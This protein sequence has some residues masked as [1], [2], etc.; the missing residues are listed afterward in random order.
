MGS[1]WWGTW[2]WL[3]EV[4]IH[5]CGVLYFAAWSLSFYPQVILNHRRRSSRGLSHDF[6][7]LNVTGFFA[8]SLYTCIFRF[9]APTRLQFSQ[10][11][12]AQPPPVETSDVCFALHGLILTLITA[13]QTV[14]FHDSNNSN[15]NI[16]PQQHQLQWSNDDGEHRPLQSPSAVA[17]SPPSSSSSL[18]PSSADIRKGAVAQ[19]E[20][21]VQVEYNG[22]DE[23]EQE[24]EEE[25]SDGLRVGVV[26]MV[27]LMWAVIGVVSVCG[28]A[29]VVSGVDAVMTMGLIKA[30]CSLFKYM[31]QVWNN[32]KRRSTHGFSIHVV[33]LDVTGGVLSMLQQ[34]LRVI[35]AHGDLT[36]FTGNVAKTALALVSLVLDAIMLTQHYVLY[37]R[38]STPTSAIV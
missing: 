9:H 30:L 13:A 1:E 22:T 33:L 8:Y 10:S 2:S 7:A 12:N 16:N 27:V 5:T 28:W 21:G 20:D 11:H 34:T 26:V 37:P 29:G 4:G 31:P 38:R 3:L 25:Y 23:E 32:A 18:P 15:I 6:V 24:E 35:Q 19:N 17:S 36:P 14:L